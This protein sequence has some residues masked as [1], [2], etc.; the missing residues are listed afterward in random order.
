MNTIQYPFS[1]RQRH[2]LAKTIW[3][4][5]FLTVTVL[6]PS[7]LRAAPLP[8]MEQQVTLMAREQS[9]DE[10]LVELF[11]LVGLP[12]AVDAQVKGT[13][14]GDWNDTA[15]ALHALA[16][17]SFQL[18]TYYD[19]QIAYIYNT[20]DLRQEVLPV[21][22]ATGNKITQQVKLLGLADRHNNLG[23]V[24]AGGLVVKG[25]PRFIEQVRE[26]S[27]TIRRNTVKYVPQVVEKLFYL[28]HAWVQDT[29]LE[30]DDQSMVVPGI[31][32]ILTQLMSDEPMANSS[33]YVP[34]YSPA[35]VTRL[36]Q[37][38][39]SQ[40]AKVE[41]STDTMLNDDALAIARS[42][43]GRSNS[44][45]DS[46]R[47]V[48]V[49]RLNAIL[50]RDLESR[51]PNY[52]ALIQALDVEPYMLEIEATII[53]ISS[54]RSKELGV[55]WR[56]QRGDGSEAL[57]GNGTESD[58]LLNPGLQLT[59]QGQG[60]ILSLALGNPAS[61]FLA[62]ISALE[63][64]GDAEIVS[65]PH[66]VTLSN[67]EAVLD[68]TQSFFVRVAASDD[69]ALFRIT[70]GTTLRVTP[71][72]YRMDGKTRIKLMVNIEDGATSEAEVDQIPV[73]GNSTIKTQAIITDG[74]SL[75]VGGMV[76]ESKRDAVTK[77]PVLGDIPGLGNMF[78]TK[79]RAGNK[80]E[81]LFLITPRLAFRD[82]FN[83]G[84]RME[85]PIL[86][87]MQGDII[88]T[89]G[90]RMKSARDAIDNSS[91][92]PSTGTL[93]V[94][95]Q[96]DKSGAV[97]S[98]P[99]QVTRPKPAQPVLPAPVTPEPGQ[100]LANQHQVAKSKRE[101]IS[102]LLRIPEKNATQ[103]GDSAASEPLETATVNLQSATS[104]S[105]PRQKF[106]VQVWQQ[107]SS[108]AKVLKKDIATDDTAENQ[109]SKDQLALR[110]K[111][112]RLKKQQS[113]PAALQPV[114]ENEWQEIKP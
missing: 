97:E 103:N 87:G 108:A 24:G 96:R 71:H 44:S 63:T 61:Q 82:G 90:N 10:F 67:T 42:M 99:S 48:A 7:L 43:Q 68:T 110:K 6:V 101:L 94:S 38:G 21:S 51:M 27:A 19:G 47:V 107:P 14:N 88:G 93:L 114:D 16:M 65:K 81:R 77:V 30:M 69:A 26:I 111:L 33:A 85:A 52:A 25:T 15:A 62:R 64:E 79:S 3:F 70:A 35:D 45:T 84:R 17:K 32:S 40:V 113:Q 98:P 53:D 5:V 11:G 2:K 72:V 106:S 74:D 89:A 37:K 20:S 34:G 78:R 73:I 58:L 12:V 36:P 31:V 86:Q 1:L 39:V 41:T 22:A 29:T 9:V 109:T 100:L 76:R 54:D 46:G 112:F 66:V 83:T 8:P 91:P 105:R 59:P 95:P 50:V 102:N 92:V 4:S 23:P 56:Y 55:N 13:V 49:P 28:R 57:V 75:L 104:A 60:G 18:V 80:V